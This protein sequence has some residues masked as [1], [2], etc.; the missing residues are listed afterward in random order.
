MERL[1][2]RLE[3]RDVERAALQAANEEL[4]RTNAEQTTTI[5]RRDERIAQLEQQTQAQ[6]GRIAQ[7]EQQT[8]AQTGRIAQ[9]EQQL[10]VIQNAAAAMFGG[11]GN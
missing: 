2:E 8:L 7:L 10:Q 1:N 6:T 3:S 5:A 4:R 9:L 11:G